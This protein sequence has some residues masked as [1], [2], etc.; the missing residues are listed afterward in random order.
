MAMIRTSG[1]TVPAMG[2]AALLLCA[3]AAAPPRTPP[4][5]GGAMEMAP[6]PTTIEAVIVDSRPEARALTVKDVR[7]HATWM[8]SFAEEVRIFGLERP[9]MRLEDLGIGDRVRISGTSRVEL[10]LK[11]HEI[12]LLDDGR[13]Y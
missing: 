8:I 10:I 2:L 6:V 12:E 3:C 13:G 4:E 5:S 9:E 11:A 1:R 7:E